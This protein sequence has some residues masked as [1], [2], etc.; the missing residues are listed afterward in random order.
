MLLAQPYAYPSE[1]TPTPKLEFVIIGLVRDVKLF[2]GVEEKDARLMVKLNESP[3]SAWALMTTGNL[4]DVG[5][6]ALTM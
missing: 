6:V 3:E 4:P 2:E 1:P 5:T